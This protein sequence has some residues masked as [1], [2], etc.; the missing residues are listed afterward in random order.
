MYEIL[1]EIDHRTENYPTPP[2]P[3]IHFEHC[4]VSLTPHRLLGTHDVRRNI[5]FIVL[6]REDWKV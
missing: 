4:V 5:R 3:L 1:D 6:I 2:L